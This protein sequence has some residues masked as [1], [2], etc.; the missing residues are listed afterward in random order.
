[1]DEWR[2][3]RRVQGYL[4]IADHGLVGDGRTCALVGRDG[5]V[6]FM[7]VPRFDSVP[8]FASLLDHRRG[9]ELLIAPVRVTE[10]R[11]R[12]VS[13]TG[14]L[15]TEMRGPDGVVEIADA[16]LLAPDARLEE[17]TRADQEEL[18]RQVRVVHGSVELRFRLSA[19]WGD[20]VSPDGRSWVLR[21]PGRPPVYV[22]LS[23][24]VSGTD[25]TITL[26]PGEVLTASLTWGDGSRRGAGCL[27]RPAACLDATTRVWRRWSDH[28]V[29]D[30]PRPDLV[31]RSAITLKLLDHVENGALIAAPTSSLPERIHGTRNWDYRYAWIRDTAYAVFALRRIGLPMEAE[32]F[33]SWALKAFRDSGRPLVL[34]DLDGHAP[35]HEVE[36]A[37]LEGYRGSAPVRWGNAAARQVQHDVYG[38]ILDCAFQW[39][40]TGGVLDP[41]LWRQL[42]RLAEEARTA[43]NRPDHGIWEVRTQGRP[44]TYSAA[45]CQVALDRAA[46]LSRMLRLPGDTE[47]WSRDAERLTARV[48]DEAWDDEA[49]ALT[50]HLGGGGLDASL[51]ALPLRR[52]VPAD[53]P[54]M[55]ATTRAVA[56]R[57]GAGGGLLHRYLPRASPDGIDEPEGAFL[58]CSFWMADNLAGQGRIDEATELFDRLCSY[59]GPL[60]LLPEQIDPS[61][62]SFL[63]NFPQAISHVGLLAT[64]VVLARAQRGVRPDLS[65]RTWEWESK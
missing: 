10:S 65:T 63:G 49:G 54:R 57:L 50:E 53:H 1:M 36:D 44:F 33:L 19:R 46:R 62:G 42:E 32:G 12:Y 15:V 14:V 17:D 22:R 11:Q 40:A 34:Y 55:V 24:P 59:A 6:S 60:G 35:P 64:A 37:A 41:G 16:F 3:L 61:D 13:G 7:C 9:G 52:V 2:A 39:A 28:V 51:L 58:L 8:L 47:G 4:P 5:A 23:R 21:G 31:L 30:V 27:D 56:D 45:M 38:E 43:W 20:E 26:E 18:L 48:L 29:R 25:S